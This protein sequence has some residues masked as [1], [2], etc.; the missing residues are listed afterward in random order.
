MVPAAERYVLLGRLKNYLG[1]ADEAVEVMTEGLRH[2]PDDVYLLRHRGHRFITL[3]RL[4]EA[5]ADLQR[6]AELAEPME[7]EIEFYQPEVE[8]EI[9]KLIL[10]QLDELMPTPVPLTPESLATYHD[11]Y[12]GTLKSC[13]WY[14]LALVHYLQRDFGLAADAFRKTLPYCVDDDMTVATTDWLYMSLQR[15]GR[16]EEAA[17]LLAAVPADM[18]ILEPS[19]HRRVQMYRGLLAPEK[20]LD[21]EGVKPIHLATQGYGLANWYLY[22]GRLDEAKELLGRI[23]GTGFKAAF[24]TIAAE[25]DLAELGSD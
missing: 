18:H 6:S 22:N 1:K 15:A 11:T 2:H 10:G 24:G 8:K 13:I 17:E 23:V 16:K 3:R 4:D 19:Y 20:L 9:A 14:H 21:P 7:D 5:L 25:I 12:K